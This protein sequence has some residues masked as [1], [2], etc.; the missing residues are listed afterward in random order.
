VHDRSIQRRLQDLA[1]L[2][3]EPVLLGVVTAVESHASWRYA[4]TVTLPD[5]RELVA[6]P[7]ALAVGSAGGGVWVPIEVGAEVLVLC[8]GGDVNRALAIAGPVSE[9][10]APPTGWGNNSVEV[11]HAG[12]T[13]VRLSEGAV[14]QAV[15]TADL[16]ADLGP[17]LT[18][19]QAAATALG[20]PTANTAALVA[21][22]PAGYRSAA[23]EVE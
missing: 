9:P 18:E 23:L 19:L 16:L 6:R 1:G 22:L 12:G 5:G 17:A 2:G 3:A 11:V 10:Q 8:P 7:V 14:V 13:V 15:V 20:L 4:Y 21:A